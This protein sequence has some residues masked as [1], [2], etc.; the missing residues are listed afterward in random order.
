M[1]TKGKIFDDLAQLMN[2]FMGVAQ[3][4]RQELESTMKGW[5][6]RWMADRNLVSRE[7][8]EMA[9]LMA[10]KA[11]EEN[12]NLSQ[13]IANLESGNKPKAAPTP[14]AAATN[15]DTEKE[16]FTTNDMAEEL[17]IDPKTLRQRLRAL[18]ILSGSGIRH[19]WNRSQYDEILERIHAKYKKRRKRRS[20]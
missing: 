10:Q 16:L 2:S 19:K 6:E 15:A 17:G 1:Q 5:F 20:S 4:T 14:K 3:D 13:R 7:E 18:K 12:E 8:F 9:L 11:R